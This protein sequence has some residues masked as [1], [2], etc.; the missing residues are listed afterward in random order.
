MDC[1]VLFGEANGP[2]IR[3][4]HKG[5]K[6]Q[7]DIGELPTQRVV[8]DTN[9]D[10]QNLHRVAGETG[11]ALYTPLRENRLG[12]ASSRDDFSS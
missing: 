9:Y 12:A 8:G 5:T 2:G 7:R 1:I 10:S 3:E 6:S 11:R 4:N